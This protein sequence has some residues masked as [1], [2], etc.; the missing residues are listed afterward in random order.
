M[1]NDEAKKKSKKKKREINNGFPFYFCI[2]TNTGNLSY[3]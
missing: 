1:E 2:K 3:N